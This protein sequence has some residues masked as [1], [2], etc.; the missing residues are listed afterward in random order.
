MNRATTL[1][2][3]LQSGG[4]RKSCVSASR[5]NLS[6]EKGFCR[7][8]AHALTPLDFCKA[9]KP[10]YVVKPVLSRRS[11]VRNSR[12]RAS[13]RHWGVPLCN[14]MKTE[15]VTQQQLDESGCSTPGCTHDHSVL[16]FHPNCHPRASL[17]VRYEKPLGEL[18]IEC[19]KCEKEV[20]RVAVAKWIDG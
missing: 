4:V 13:L 20:L 18:V 5:Q 15:T 1:F 16:Y 10:N 11:D 6:K 9:T 7:A 3:F 14:L 17:E 19:C 2:K 12:R 8:K